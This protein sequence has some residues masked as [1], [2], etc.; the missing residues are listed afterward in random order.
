MSKREIF[1]ILFKYKWGILSFWA[2]AVVLVTLFSFLWPP[3]YEAF[4]KVLIKIKFSPGVSA[5]IY[6]THMPVI[7][8]ITLM[9]EM[10]TEKEILSSRPVMESVVRKLKLYLPYK[11]EKPTGIMGRLRFYMRK[12][13]T[14]VLDLPNKIMILLRITRPPTEA[15]M[16]QAT[17]ESLPKQIEAVQIP[18]SNVL[19]IGLR[20]WYPDRIT[21]TVDAITNEYIRYHILVYGRSDAEQF[22]DEQILKARQELED[23]E[24]GFRS[25][26]SQQAFTSYDKM[27][28]LLLGKF[29][30]LDSRLTE[31]KKDIINQESK[32]ANIR[33]I[34][35]ENPETVIPTIEIRVEPIISQLQKILLDAR[36]RLKLAKERFAPGHSQVVTLE[37]EVAEIQSSVKREVDKIIELEAT[38]LSIYQAEEQALQTTLDKLSK[39]VKE[40][41]E[42]KVIFDRYQRALEEQ[43][44]IT[45]QLIKKREEAKFSSMEDQRVVNVTVVSPASIPLLPSG[46]NKILNISLALALAPILALALAFFFESINHGFRNEEDVR[47]YLEL[48]MLVSFG[49]W[50]KGRE[51]EISE[52]EQ[53]G[54]RLYGGILSAREE[55]RTLLMTSCQSGEGT[56]TIARNLAKSLATFRDRKV[57][58]VDAN[59]QHLA[60]AFD[61]GSES[62]PTPLN[63]IGGNV[64]LIQK[65]ADSELFLMTKED[66]LPQVDRDWDKKVFENLFQHLKDEFHFVVFDCPPVGL[67]ALT[68]RLASV[69]DGVVLVIQAE[70][71]TR[72]AAA[73]AK[74][75]LEEA[76]GTVLGVVLNQRK[77]FIPEFIYRKL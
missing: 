69:A 19:K 51:P 29:V 47:E 23:Q 20:G 21:E 64:R 74:E 44:D 63:G 75:L 40:L 46:P 65:T 77:L 55:T 57:L 18:E 3:S 39:G 17:I 12:T 37:N 43:I 33:K 71:T 53:V 54:K 28:T 6:P 56:T 76:G 73:K 7:R 27:E 62:P 67:T 13:I 66:F 35:E 68:P 24:E 14:F 52:T 4:S 58:L 41:P 72:E 10:N 11:E 25:F 42:K 22:F 60:S 49:E 70:Q 34:L 1:Y 36:L 32:V 8:T 2:I 30:E 9:E 48:P 50:E 38:K 26:K 59:P 16:F 31:V 5:S 45:N 61:V 15:E